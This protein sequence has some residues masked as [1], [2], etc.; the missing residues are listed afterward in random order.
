MLVLDLLKESNKS[1]VSRS[2][3][4]PLGLLSV[5]DHKTYSLKQFYL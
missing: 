5:P 2:R 4:R 1:V 3:S